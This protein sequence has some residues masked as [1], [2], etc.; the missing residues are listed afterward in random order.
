[1]H[2]ETMR[3]VQ[4]P[5]QQATREPLKLLGIIERDL[6]RLNVCR[7]ECEFAL[8]FSDLARTFTTAFGL[9]N[10]PSSI[11]N[12]ETFLSAAAAFVELK[13]FQAASAKGQEL[14]E[15][16]AMV[17]TIEK[18]FRSVP[19]LYARMLQLGQQMADDY[20]NQDM[21]EAKQLYNGLIVELNK[22]FAQFNVAPLVAL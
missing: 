13:T 7:A 8:P 4:K 18:G 22:L 6:L 14:Q 12:A 11:P 21:R 15:L 19:A 1:M 20:C 16:V 17:A 10:E 3:R 9:P 5:F 2:T